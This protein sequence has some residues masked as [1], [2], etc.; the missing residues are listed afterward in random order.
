M[1]ACEIN[2]HT[3]TRRCKHARG[4]AADYCKAAVMYG[5]KVLG[6]SE[7]SPF[8]DDHLSETRLT[9]GEM[10][11]YC[12]ETAAAGKDFPELCIL[13]GLEVD[14]DT[15]C[16]PEFFV[17]LKEK[18]KLHF[19]AAGAHFVRN[20]E[21]ALINAGINKHHREE[22][23]LLFIEKTIRLIESGAFSF[24]THPDMIAG[25]IDAMTTEIE[26]M[27]ISLAH[28]SIRHRTPLEINA[29]GLRK[30]VVEYP[31][32]EQRNPYPYLPFWQICG[33]LQVPCIVGSDAH[34]PEDLGSSSVAAA[35][36]IAGLAGLTP[37]NAE[38]F[39]TITGNRK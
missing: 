23:V 15:D 33:K 13:T 25:S 8:P 27:F 10:D 30:A 19:L 5:I 21:G 16:P 18:Y 37:C 7:H 9:F 6:F 3:H 31:G 28:A 20:S 17:E 26:K 2:L 38:T 36:R 39:R 35:Y 24:I 32:G 1:N 29:Y 34:A 4:C 11:E 14:T 22:T 12:R